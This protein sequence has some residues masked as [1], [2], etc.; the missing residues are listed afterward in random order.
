MIPIPA[1][2]TV[3]TPGSHNW[4]EDGILFS[5]CKDRY[6]LDIAEAKAI[7]GAFKQLSEKPLPLFVDLHTS[8]GQSSEARTYFS[9]DPTHIET[10]TAVALFVSNPVSRVIANVY[11]GLVKPAKPT[12]LFTDRAEAVAWL[13]QHKDS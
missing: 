8:S 2:D 6:Y 1:Q 5:I 11:M 4:V 7:T 3:E 10:Y 12:R 9:S 13:S